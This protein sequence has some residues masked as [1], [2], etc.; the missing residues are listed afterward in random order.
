MP[1]A[2]DLDLAMNDRRD[3]LNGLDPVRI[4]PLRRQ[5]PNR[6][7]LA[8]PRILTPLRF[9][10]RDWHRARGLALDVGQRRQS[11]SAL[12]QI[13]ARHTREPDFEFPRIQPRLPEPTTNVRQLSQSQ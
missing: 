11:P 12:R 8:T 10:R 9:G 1:T 7:F 5:R 6:L 3:R 4:R 2:F 13:Q